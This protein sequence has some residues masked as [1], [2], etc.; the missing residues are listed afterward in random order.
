MAVEVGVATG[1][2]TPRSRQT[3]RDDLREA[4][5]ERDARGLKDRPE[6][7]MTRTGTTKLPRPEQS[8]SNDTPPSS[9]R[10]AGDM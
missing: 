6:G 8:F 7:R 9:E 3:R 5:D 10:D 4:D 2:M 1:R